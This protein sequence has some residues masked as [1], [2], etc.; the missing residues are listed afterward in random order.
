MF[1]RILSKYLLLWLVLVCVLGFSWKTLFGE[2]AP[3]PFGL[4]ANQMATL[5][6]VTMLAVGSLLPP[7]EVKGVVKNW[8]KILGGTFVQYVSMPLLAFCV[9][10]AFHLT[11]GYF[12]GITH[13]T[14]AI[15]VIGMTWRGMPD[16][17]GQE[18]ICS[19]NRCF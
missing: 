3:N 14:V 12:I 8:P 9:A 19:S 1:K 4:D 13:L 5:I 11:G 18:E 15:C 7:D 16:I 6:S 17:Y 10:K 2:S